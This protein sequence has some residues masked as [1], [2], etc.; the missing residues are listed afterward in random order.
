MCIKMNFV[1]HES[2]GFKP[3]VTI[4]SNDKRNKKQLLVELTT[5]R[6]Q[7]IK[8]KNFN[9]ELDIIKEIATIVVL[10]PRNVLEKY[11]NG[12]TRHEVERL[13]CFTNYN[14][15]HKSHYF[16]KNLLITRFVDM[17]YKDTFLKQLQIIQDKIEQ[18]QHHKKKIIKTIEELDS[19]IKPY[20]SLSLDQLNNEIKPLK[21][22]ESYILKRLA[23]NNSFTNLIINLG[24]RLVDLRMNKQQLILS[25][26]IQVENIR[27]QTKLANIQNNYKNRRSSF[28]HSKTR[29]TFDRTYLNIPYKDKDSAKNL[30][31]RWD[32][33]E[34]KWYIYIKEILPDFKK[35]ILEKWSIID[36]SPKVSK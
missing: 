27:L 25:S 33:I 20:L 34:R 1:I 24:K 23:N 30:G 28:K 12:Y 17:C 32:S 29:S 13:A 3:P 10:L 21:L 11:L 19:D 31:A 7:I 15:V 14:F 8:T 5:R 6:L 26:V 18:K 4:P 9:K 36:I 16:T 35:T 22:K 2:N